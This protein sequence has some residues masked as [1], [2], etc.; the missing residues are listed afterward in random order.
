MTHDQ[1][2][3][4]KTRQQPACSGQ[5]A[6]PLNWPAINTKPQAADGQRRFAA[7]HRRCGGIRY[8][9]ALPAPQPV[10]VDYFQDGMPVA[11][12]TTFLVNVNTLAAFPLLQGA[13]EKPALISRLDDVFQIALNGGQK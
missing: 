6:A 13:V 9:D 3:I 1:V 10:M 7:A 2:N 5:K 11:T 8:P 12:P 4:K